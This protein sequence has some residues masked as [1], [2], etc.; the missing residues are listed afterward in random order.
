[1]RIDDGH[2]QRISAALQA[3]LEW[4]TRIGLFWLTEPFADTDLYLTVTPRGLST[5]AWECDAAAL[6]PREAEESF[7]SAVRDFYKVAIVDRGYEIE[8]LQGQDKNGLPLCLAFLALS[9]LAV[10]HM[11]RDDVNRATAFYPRLIQ[12]LGL[13]ERNKRPPGFKEQ[14]FENLWLYVRAWTEAR[15]TRPLYIPPP[16]Y[17]QYENYPQAH[18][19]L[20]EVDLERLPE[21]FRWARYSPESHIDPDRLRA[22][23]LEWVY[24][25]SPFTRQGMAACNDQRLAG[26]VQEV[27]QELKAW[28]GGGR[29]EQGRQVANVELHLELVRGMPQL[30]FLARKP[31][32]FPDAFDDG[33]HRFESLEGWYDPV[34]VPRKE[35]RALIDGFEWVSVDGSTNV[36][37]RRL[38]AA[39]IAFVRSEE[40]AGLVS[41]RRLISG[42]D[43]AVLY[44]TSVADVVEQTLAALLGGSAPR[45]MKGAPGLPSDWIVSG[46]FRVSQFPADWDPPIEALQVDSVVDFFTIGGLRVGRRS[47]W[48]V[49]A[50]PVLQVSG[51]QDFVEV[52]KSRV[53]IKGGVVEWMGVVKRP[54]M[55]S[56]RAGRAHRNIEIVEPTVCAQLPALIEAG[57]G[58][59]R[60][61][62]G[63]PQGTWLVLGAEPGALMSL[64]L[65]MDELVELEFEPVWALPKG[66]GGK[67]A[68]LF[69]PSDERCPV[70]RPRGSAREQA[71]ARAVRAAERLRAPIVVV[72]SEAKAVAERSWDQFVQAVHSWGAP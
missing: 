11:H 6:T 65:A 55:Y 60:Y 45:P 19:V 49:G 48:L 33:V 14:Q 41:R 21:F 38:G 17:R 22:D 39:A 23:L 26:V 29:D 31:P 40:M 1:M 53:K 16:K 25:K 69:F 10:H 72:D 24:A 54:G 46:V 5:A 7:V 64:E 57:Q 30:S 37:L 43:C 61:W 52:N 28:D 56:V 70:R 4:N 63:I 68:L 2:T 66:R 62:A 42:V 67:D 36:V 58:A 47:S 13:G 3:Y 18:S 35:G 44:H 50:P 8:F 27:A 9:V 20:R 12:L 32:G 59:T 15:G 34:P 71:W 51:V